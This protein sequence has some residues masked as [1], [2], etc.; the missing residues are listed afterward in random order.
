MPANRRGGTTI[1]EAGDERFPL[2]NRLLDGWKRKRR[3]VAGPAVPHLGDPEPVRVGIVL[4]DDVA[5]A[6]RHV[7][8]TRQEHPAKFLSLAWDRRNLRDQPVHIFS[9]LRKH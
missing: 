7:V 8:D 4:G 3:L 1:A 6:T 5:Q 9:P 2:R